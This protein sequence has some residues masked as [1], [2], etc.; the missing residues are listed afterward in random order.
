VP[1]FD[2]LVLRLRARVHSCECTGSLV[3][4]LCARVLAGP[5]SMMSR[6]PTCLGTAQCPLPFLSTASEKMCD[7][8]QNLEEGATFLRKCHH[9]YPVSLFA[10]YLQKIRIL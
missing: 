1:R 5:N 2:G 10:M 6:P 8:N 7:S 4:R 3:L 9:G